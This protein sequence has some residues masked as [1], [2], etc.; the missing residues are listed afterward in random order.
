MVEE[1]CGSVVCLPSVAYTLTFWCPCCSSR[2][3]LVLLAMSSDP[4][5]LLPT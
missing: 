4:A 5:E 2:C 3:V 1:D